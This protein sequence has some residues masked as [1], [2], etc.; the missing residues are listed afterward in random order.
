MVAD[1]RLVNHFDAS[2]QPFVPPFHDRGVF[3]NR[4][5]IVGVAHHVQKGYP[6]SGERPEVVLGIVGVASGSQRPFFRHPVA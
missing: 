3:G 1:S 5:N 4:D 6:V 2:A